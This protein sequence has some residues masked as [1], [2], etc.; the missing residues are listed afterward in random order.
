MSWHVEPEP[1]GAQSAGKGAAVN[2][3]RVSWII[4][5]WADTPEDAARLALVTQRDPDSIATVFEV[6]D[7]GN[8]HHIDAEDGERVADFRG[9]CAAPEPQS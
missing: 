2:H 1:K 7:C 4:D 6:S 5:I 8:V 9:Y 3:Y